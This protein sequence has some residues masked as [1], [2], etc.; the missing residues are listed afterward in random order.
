MNTNLPQR[1]QIGFI[2]KIKNWVKKL[3]SKKDIKS[4]PEEN[5]TKKE[6]IQKKEDFLSVIKKQTNQEVIVFQ[7]RLESGLMR[8][9]E[10]SDE[11]YE[12]VISLYE[13]QINEMHNKLNMYKQKLM[14]IRKAGEQQ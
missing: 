14:D 10:L 8:A 1:I 3:T 6:D 7:E 9:S 11:Q 13:S 4:E 5:E 12:E 2:Q